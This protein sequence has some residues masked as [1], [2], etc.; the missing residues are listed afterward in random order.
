MSPRSTYLVTALMLLCFAFEQKAQHFQFSQFYA[1]PTYLNPAFT[2]A[3]VCGRVS[4]NYRNQ[5]SG[6]PGTFTSY[7]AAYDHYLRTA[8]SGIGL[9][10][11][12]DQAGIGSLATT[13]LTGL[14]AYEVRLSKKLMGRAGF[15]AGMIQRSADLSKFVFSDQLRDGKELSSETGSSIRSTYFDV[16]TGILLYSRSSWFGFAATHINRPNQSL[17]NGDS[18]LPAELK[19]HGGYKFVIEE[20][21]SS[22]PSLAMNNFVTLAANFKKQQKFNQLDLGIYYTRNAIVLG[23]WYRGIPAFKPVTGYQNNDAIIFLFGV[24]VQKYKVGYSFDFTV[25]KLTHGASK[26]A[27]ELSM[28]YQFC[29]FKKMKRRKSGL[30]ACPKF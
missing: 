27:H 30:I 18:P 2:G 25:S 11:F 24:N 15:S 9:Q 5:W 29:T 13:Q 17:L 3:N 26:G 19:F 7:M 12:R 8:K 1:A 21:E 22:N 6:I 23:A 16:G 14:Y 10:V 28:S 4:L 20:L